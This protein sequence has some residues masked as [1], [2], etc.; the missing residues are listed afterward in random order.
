MDWQKVKTAYFIGVK[1]VGMTMLAEFLSRQGVKVEGSDVPESFMTDPVLKKAGVKVYEN[2][3]A[4]R[5]P[6]KYDLIVYSTAYNGTNAEVA[7][8]LA[9]RSKVCTYAEALSKVFNYR[10]GI[11]V[12]GSHGKT[13]T[14]AWL[15]FVLDRLGLKPSVMVGSCV[16]QFGGASLSGDSDILII[17]ADE[18]QNKLKNFEPKDI[19]LTGIDYDHPDFFPTFD[20]YS[21]VFADFIAKLGTKG[22]L[23]ANFDDPEVKR[24]SGECQGRVI[25][26]AVNAEADFKASELRLDR[27]RQ[28]FK[29][30][31]QGNDLGTFHTSL[32]GAHNVSNVLAVIAFAMEYNPKLVDLRQAVE[33]FAGTSRRMEKKGSFKGAQIYDDYAHHPT[34]IK[35]TLAALRALRPNDKLTVVFHPHTFTRT[36]ALLKDFSESFDQAD[37]VVLLDIY[38]SAREVQGGVSSQD[39]KNRIMDHKPSAKVFFLP[40]FK[41]AEQYLK[42]TAGPNQAIVLMGAG[43]VFRLAEQLK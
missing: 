9:S 19:I 4:S 26:Y 25:S 12:A 11:A 32:I 8:A 29:V 43:D 7:A 27:E 42:E 16:P 14:T 30:S 20:E 28:Y 34:E 3:D 2:F 17:E 38:G 24:L 18:Y 35:A 5:L 21:G 33:E 40:T 6:G 39:L 36:K 10:Q 15:G 23:V 37:E 22:K 41:E 31:W 1:G 13:T